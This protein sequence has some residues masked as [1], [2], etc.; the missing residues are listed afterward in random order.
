MVKIIRTITSQIV[1]FYDASFS[2]Q[3]QIWLPH[4]HP[5]HPGAE[6]KPTSSS[7]KKS[8][9]SADKASIETGAEK[10]SVS[11][12]GAENRK[13]SLPE[14][15]LTKDTPAHTTSN[16]EQSTKRT[17]EESTSA[18]GV[19]DPEVYL[20][21]LPVTDSCQVVRNKVNRLIESGEMKVGDSCTAIGVS[22]NAY[23]N[24]MHKHG[25]MKGAEC[26]A[27]PN[28]AAFFQKR[29]E[30]GL[31]LP[32][33]K[34]KTKDD[35]K[36]GKDSKAE[37]EKLDIDG[38]ELYGEET[39]SVPF[40]DTCDDIR[41]QITAYLKKPGVTQAQ[42]GRD[43]LKQ[44]HTDRAPKGIS[45]SQIQA[46]RSKKGPD[47]GNTSSVFY[48]AYVFFEKMRIKQNKPKSEKRKEM[49]EAWGPGGFD[50]EH[51]S[52]TTGILCE[53]GDIV[54]K[55][56]FGRMHSY[57]PHEMAAEARLDD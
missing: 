44:F 45:G 50:I 43:L 33:K 8:P 16:E 51:N 48:G 39:D 14:V 38:I 29:D 34:Q 11:T 19:D 5:H 49:E 26:A 28:A 46:F 53:M 47:V 54:T 1:S 18:P 13:D 10:N 41:R 52:A 22:S 30:A 20:G 42:F 31:K 57:K 37:A 40:Y 24:F 23:Y 12:T 2:Y 32:T 3:S 7:M 56:K 55:D 35:G 25:A 36:G 21:Q 15:D 6:P 17:H 27:Y 9:G 4:Q